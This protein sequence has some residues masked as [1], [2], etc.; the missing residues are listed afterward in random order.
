M[1]HDYIY[2]N[3]AAGNLS[4]LPSDSPKVLTTCQILFG[5]GCY[6]LQYKYLCLNALYRRG[7]GDMR[8]ITAA[9]L[10]VNTMVARLL[11]DREQ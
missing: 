1:S 2:S 9:D 10:V 11:P 4:C 8:L 6:C 5:G 7:S 3:R